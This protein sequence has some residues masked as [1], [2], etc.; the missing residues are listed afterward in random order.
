MSR[1]ESFIRRL[2]AQR[3]CL[4]WAVAAITGRPGV[5]LELG[6][7]NG[8]SYDH[9]AS[10]LEP[11]RALYAFDRVCAAHPA[12]IPPSG[13]LILGDLS[14]TLPR[15]AARGLVVALVHADLGSGDDAA[16]AAQARLL[17]PIIATLLAPEGLV[18]SDQALDDAALR[19]LA[20]PALVPA[21]RYFVYRRAAARSTITGT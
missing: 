2:D 21:D 6:L 1:L 14:E 13:R 12:S 17:A 11:G 3:R 7:G 4:D 19:P 9:L 5:V 16:N 18:L 15:F 8:R 20:P 10:R